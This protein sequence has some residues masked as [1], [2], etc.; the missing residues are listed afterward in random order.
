MRTC[1]RGTA[2]IASLSALFFLGLR[3]C[4]KR[5]KKPVEPSLHALCRGVVFGEQGLF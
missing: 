1:G 5:V 2:C 4:K 3:L